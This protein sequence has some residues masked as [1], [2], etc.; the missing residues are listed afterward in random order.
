MVN[1]KNRHII[2]SNNLSEESYFISIL[3]EAY[4]CGLL[5]DSDIENIQ[6][7][8]IDFLAYKSENYNGGESSSIRVE[9]A[10]NI[11][12]SNLYTIGLYLKSLPDA[13]SAVS[14]LKSTRIDEIYKK[15]RDLIDEKIRTVKH[16]YKLAKK[17]K[18]FTL[19]YTY[20]ATLDDDGIGIFFRSYNPDYEAHETPAS[21]DYQLCNPV[22]NLEGIEFIHKYLE[23]LLIEN[24][25]CRNFDTQDIHYLLYGY[26][27]G[28]KDL[29]INIFEHV[30]TAGL[31][32]LLA[33]KSIKKLDISKD[34]IQFLNRELSKDTN[35]SLALKIQNAAKKLIEKM[36]ITNPLVQEYIERS[37]HKVTSNIAYGIKT[38]ALDKVFVTPI[39]PDLKPKIKFSS[40]VKMEDE[41][42]R[43]LINQ[44]LVCEYSLNKIAIIKENVESFNDLEDILFDAELNGEEKALVFD[45]LEDIEVAALIKRHPFK[46]DIQAI[47]LSE[48]EHELRLD[49]QKYIDNLST[50]RKGRIFKM[51]NV[52]I[53][54]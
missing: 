10:E 16:I 54:G 12:K 34:E 52:L 27:E 1:I 28:Y 25:F 45:I 17:N 9:V 43:K 37:L 3:Q 24:E 22:I 13:D 46:S 7:Q 26:D 6:L 41:D 40:G 2:D 30:L 19:N 11:M 21:I 38:N 23:G 18:V 8:C 51:V 5:Y 4:A 39:N 42:Y 53:D 44:L 48:A 49:L 36:N 15:G 50:D 20:N 32:C 14:E 31:G 33:N 47:D 29:L 35:Y